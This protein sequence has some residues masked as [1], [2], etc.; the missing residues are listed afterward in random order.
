MEF[1]LIMYC[2]INDNGDDHDY[3]V[4]CVQAFCSFAFFIIFFAACLCDKTM[5]CRCIGLY[6]IR[7]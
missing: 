5:T 3:H 6:A 4:R 1:F 7:F 2:L